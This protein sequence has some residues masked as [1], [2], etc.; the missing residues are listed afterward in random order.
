[1]AMI[2]GQVH[3]DREVVSRKVI[4]GGDSPF[5]KQ[6]TEWVSKTDPNEKIVAMSLSDLIKNREDQQKK[7][8]TT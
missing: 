8:T 3:L 1:M 2:R 4:A 7:K 5:K 6:G